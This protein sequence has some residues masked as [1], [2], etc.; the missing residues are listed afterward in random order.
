MENEDMI[1]RKM[2]Q[3]RESLTEKI[4]TL[5][6]KLS[7]SVE[8]VTAAVS[9]AKETVHEGVESVKDFMDVKGH[10]ERHPWLMIGGAVACGY[11]AGAVLARTPERE[12]APVSTPAPAP[13]KTLPPQ[14]NGRHKREKETA[15]PGG[16]WLSALAPEFDMLK[17]MALSATLSAVRDVVA[18][19]APPALLGH[20]RLFFDNITRKMGG[21]P[22]PAQERP[23]A[24][25]LAPA[26]RP[27]SGGT[28]EGGWDPEK[29]R[30]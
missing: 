24:P 19:E 8:E 27:G 2:E 4:D 16:G 17:S 23:P 20:V 5:E 11:V 26:P 12:P 28:A 30:W 14:G 22:L 29:P 6:K 3:T 9:T 1:R 25:P 18:A 13:L 10:V 15:R 21:E 7:E